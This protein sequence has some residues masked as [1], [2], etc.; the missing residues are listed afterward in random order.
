M[1]CWK[2]LSFIS[3]AYK[4]AFDKS[5][6]KETC[7]NLISRLLGEIENE[8]MQTDDDQSS[9]TEPM[10]IDME[11]YL[12]EHFGNFLSEIIQNAETKSTSN[13]YSINS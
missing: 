4:S 7:E 5:V 12:I 3:R 6:L 10:E 9:L 2:I 11:K 8:E 13:W 1:F